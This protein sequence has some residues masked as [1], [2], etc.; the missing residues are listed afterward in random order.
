MSDHTF[1]VRPLTPRTDDTQARAIAVELNA[2]HQRI[3]QRPFT[4]AHARRIEQN[5]SAIRRLLA[6]APCTPVTQ[7]PTAARLALRSEVFNA[8]GG[9]CV[10]CG[11]TDHR[12][13][14]I[15][16]INPCGRKRPKDIYR[17]VRSEGY[18]R[19]RYQVLCLNCNQMKGDGAACPHQKGH[20][21][22]TPPQAE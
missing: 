5:L 20:H 11:E 8:L 17:R 10:C 15:D 18:P 14:T 16:H 22:E 7:E 1:N 6:G 19:D 21:E 4:D 2:I 3:H 12:A 13:L 9:R